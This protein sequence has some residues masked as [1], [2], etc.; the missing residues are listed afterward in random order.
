[1]DYYDGNSVTGLWNYAQHYAMSD[2]A[3][4][5]TYGPSTPGALNVVAAQT[6]GAICAPPSDGSAINTAPCSAPSGLH[7]TSPAASNITARPVQP[8]GPGTVIGDD[9]PTYDICSYLP[10][11]DRGDGDT[12]AD[13]I[14][15]G[16]QNIGD[17]LTA[18]NT[19]W[20]WFRGRLR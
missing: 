10:G 1:M 6:Y 14:T 17:E 12:P 15:M 11:A 7:T 19:T 16:G 20:G 8:A 4:G 18:S 2:N 13:T 9:D 5:T 3:D